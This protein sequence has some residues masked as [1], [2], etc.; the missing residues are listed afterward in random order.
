MARL[1][2]RTMAYLNMPRVIAGAAIVGPKEG[3]GP[4][5]RAFDQVVDDDR[6]G[7]DTYEQAEAELM[8]R[9]AHLALRKAAL[10]PGQL[11]L[12]IAGDLEQQ[13]LA[14]T[15][16]ARELGAGF[17]GVYGAC[18]TIAEAMLV[19][20][21]LVDA[22]QADNALCV[23]SSH[24]STAER[25][26]RYP[27]ELGNQRTPSSQ[28]TATG[29]GAVALAAGGGRALARVELGTYGRVVD[30]DIPD[31]NNMGAAMAPAAADTLCAHFAD[32]GR[33]PGD[34]DLIVTG[35]LGRIGRE[36]LCDLM[37]GR[38][39]PLPDERLMDC[40]A[41]MFTLEQ[42]SCAGGSGCACLACVFASKLLAG[43]SAGEY[44]RL[45]I[46]GTGA[47]LSPVSSLQGE[48]IPSI[49]H[50]LALTGP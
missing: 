4:L 29:A 15:I 25:E 6:L 30:Y 7:R 23:T 46:V 9:A 42:D 41:S 17:L 48:S 32:T 14:A 19:G 18:S 8:T 10:R 22:G 39:C 37:A 43:L 13:I 2:A 33:A 12:M 28:R 40:G 36:L 35:D 20:A 21:A 38:G 50:A 11:Q 44:R 45:L 27:Q 26:F 49:A 3:A 47:L 24:F 5:G 31:A 1:G 34:Y 16:C